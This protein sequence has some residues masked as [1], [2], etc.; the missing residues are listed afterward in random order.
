ML[1][2]ELQRKTPSSVSIP[3]PVCPHYNPATNLFKAVLLCDGCA[4][5]QGVPS[6]TQ[7]FIQSFP[8]QH[9]TGYDQF[10][11]PISI[12]LGLLRWPSICFLNRS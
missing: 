2:I 9:Q 7:E 11:Q 4:R 1:E 3:I 5:S 6:A 8:L 10:H 12:Q